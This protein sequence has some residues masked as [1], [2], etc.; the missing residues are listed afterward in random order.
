MPS[1]KKVAV[2]AGV[3]TL[4]LGGVLVGLGQVGGDNAEDFPEFNKNPGLTINDLGKSDAK[5]EVKDDAA[6]SSERPGEI[7]LKGDEVKNLAKDS[8]PAI[9]DFCRTSNLEAGEGKNN[10]GGTC[11]SY[12][13]GEVAKNSVRVTVE[14]PPT[15]VNKGDKF[16]IKI[17]IEDNKGPLDLNAFTFDESGGAGTTFL[18]NPGKLDK[19]GRPLA[20][21]HLGITKLAGGINGLPGNDYDAAFKGVQGF[22]GNVSATVEGL[23][24]GFYRADIYVSQPGHLALPTA[25]ATQVQAFDTFRFEVN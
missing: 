21:A 10:K 2:A 18:E 7:D 25:T 24:P 14:N 22:K 19:D 13:I 8:N 1:S 6:K 12:P 11:I 16:T 23:E 3:G 9:T 20:H 17:R 5:E 15:V 4:M